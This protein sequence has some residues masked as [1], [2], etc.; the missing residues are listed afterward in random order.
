MSSEV[1]SDTKPVKV[2]TWSELKDR[3]P[4]YALV[5][6][7]D[8]V[9]VR[10]GGEVSVLYGRCLHRGALMSDGHVDG[11]NLIC[12]V[13][14]WDYR[15]DT[16]VSEYDNDEALERFSA[17]IDEGADAVYVDEDEVRAWQQGHP[18]PYKRD[19]YLGLYALSL[20]H[21]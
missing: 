17:W 5:A 8:L 11:D 10:Y 3:E 19:D 14:Q 12:G 13:H 4:A 7:V 20:I 2:A 9:V 16:G 18:Q 1:Q 15:L 6:A 21:I